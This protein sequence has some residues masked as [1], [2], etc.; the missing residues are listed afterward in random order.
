MEIRHINES[1]LNRY[2]ATKIQ[3]IKSRLHDNSI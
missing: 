1:N 3:I 2:V